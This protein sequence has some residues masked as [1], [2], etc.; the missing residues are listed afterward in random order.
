MKKYRILVVDD[1]QAWLQTIELILD[2]KYE[3]ELTSDPAKAVELVRSSFFSLAILDQRISPDVSG[4]ELF[5]QLR[6]FQHDLRAI[7]LTGYA[8]VKDAVRSM[9][10]GIFDYIEKG[11]RDLAGELRASVEKALLENPL[12]PLIAKGESA[13]LELKSS[14]RWDLQRNK[15]NP[16]MEAVVV[17]TVAGFLNSEHG[18]VLL[19]GVDD[20][21]QAIGLQH[22]YETLKRK[23]RDGFEIFLMTLL[24]DALGKDVTPLLHIDFHEI[25]GKDVCRVSAKP[26]PKA[27]FVNRQRFFI[28]AG[29]G[30]RELSMQESYEYWKTRGM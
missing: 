17:K 27:V 30:T 4:A 24:L 22:D 6:D 2:G 16:E 21:G 14:A 7:I 10:A 18:G 25:D 28:R 26:A 8:G 23:D 1:D 9:Q 11:E 15:P 20:S 3:L 5:G 19:I 12:T 13:T 29:N